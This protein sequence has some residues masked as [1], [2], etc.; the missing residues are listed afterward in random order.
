MV[1][2]GSPAKRRRTIKVRLPRAAKITLE[3]FQNRA[4]ALFPDAITRIILYGS[5]AR[6]QAKA[7]SDLDVVVVLNKEKQ[8]TKAYI[9]GPGDIRWRNLVDAGVDSM[10]DKGPF[11][12]V[13]VIGEDVYQS[14]LSIARAAREEGVVL[15]EAPR[16]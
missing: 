10:V 2:I 7:N 3:N 11:I 1:S 8:P 4:L 9:G 12:S 15:W 13:L 6:G 14:G 16:T 5:Y